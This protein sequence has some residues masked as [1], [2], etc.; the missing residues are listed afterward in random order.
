MEE[1]KKSKEEKKETEERLFR[2][3]NACD[4]KTKMVIMLGTFWPVFVDS[5]LF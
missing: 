5:F 4:K 2:G 1:E 3:D